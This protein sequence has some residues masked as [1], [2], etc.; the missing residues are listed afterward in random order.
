M[1]TLNPRGEA[2]VQAARTDSATW[3]QQHLYAW[4]H[5]PTFQ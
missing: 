1:H 5:K 2:T 3:Q 4:M